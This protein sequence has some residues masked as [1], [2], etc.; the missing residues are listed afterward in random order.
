MIRNI[1]PVKP[2]ITRKPNGVWV[3]IR[4]SAGY[5]DNELLL[6]QQTEKEPTIRF[7]FL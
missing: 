4:H 1:E 2:W 3:G 5:V 6:Q 7:T